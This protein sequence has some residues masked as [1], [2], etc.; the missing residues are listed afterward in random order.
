MC[1]YW[2][3]ADGLWGEFIKQSKVLIQILDTILCTQ[4]KSK[5]SL[6]AISQKNEKLFVLWEQKWS[7]T[8]FCSVVKQA[9]MWG[10]VKM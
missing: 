1:F 8:V 3:N 5:T 7:S 10:A 9:R 4:L 2:K 6:K